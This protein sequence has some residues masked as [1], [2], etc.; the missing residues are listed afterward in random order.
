VLARAPGV[1]LSAGDAGGSTPLHHAAAAGCCHVV[2][3]LW[4]VQ[5]VAL[6]AGE[7]GGGSV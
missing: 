2:E 4:P 1:L 3:V 5:G 6:D 7:R